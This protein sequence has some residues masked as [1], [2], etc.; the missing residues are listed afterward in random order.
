MLS[1]VM[2]GTSVP[3]TGAPLNVSVKPV[4][5]SPLTTTQ[6]AHGT[7]ALIAAWTLAV[8]YSWPFPPITGESPALN[9][10]WNGALAVT[11]AVPVAAAPDGA[12]LGA[13]TYWKVVGAGI[14][15]TANVPL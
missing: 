6:A 4:L 11:V 9:P 5:P 7:S 8:L 10:I 12:R 15:V 3:A 2:F 13:A 14:A 1:S